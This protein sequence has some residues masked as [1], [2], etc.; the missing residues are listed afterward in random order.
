MKKI[1]EL[2]AGNSAAGNMLKLGGGTALGQLFSVLVLP[3]VSRQYDPIQ[4]GYFGIF[5]A[6]IAI[7]SVVVGLRYEMATP[8]ADSEEEADQLLTLS[9]LTGVVISALSGLVYFGLHYFNIGGYGHLAGWSTWLLILT[10]VLTGAFSSLRFWFVRR[11]DFGGISKAMVQQ[12]FIRALVPVML[13]FLRFDW[14]GLALGEVV[15]RVSGVFS[16]GRTAW[17]GIQVALKDRGGLIATARK[18]RAMPLQMMPSSLID[19]LAF[20]VSVPLFFGLYGGV[21]AGLYSMAMTVIAI[22]SGLIAAS[23]G[24]VFHQH[25]ADLARGNREGISGYV[26]SSG[27]KLL[28]IAIAIYIPVGV[29]SYIL[30]GPVLGAKWLPL[31]WMLPELVPMVILSSLCGPLSRVLVVVNRVDLKL[32]VDV[33]TL[34]LTLGPILGCAYLKTSFT[35]AFGT[36]C[37]AM[38]VSR[39]LYAW[40]IWV[41]SL[42]QHQRLLVRG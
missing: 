29:L 40:V 15:G 14:I 19:S 42:P 12:G 21:S 1:R 31:S 7:A 30:A 11:A 5:G 41:A 17:T 22:P 16:L 32:Y 24:D 13:G 36:Y 34:V 18:H 37:F 26:L 25:L 9:L 4:R 6:Y 23:V 2:I 10:L 33:L 38:F 28:K 27:T 39:V 8:S 3:I 35:I 20:S